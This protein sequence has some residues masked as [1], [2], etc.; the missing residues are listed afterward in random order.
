MVALQGGDAGDPAALAD[1]GRTSRSP[2]STSVYRNLDVMLAPSDVVGES[3][4]NP[5]LD[6]VVEDLDAPG[7]LVESGGA[8][9]VFPPGFTNRD[10]EPLPLIVRKCDE[11]YG[12]AAT[13]LAAIRDRVGTSRRRMLYVV[14]APQAQH[15]EMCFAVARMAGW[16]P[17]GERGEHVAFGNGARS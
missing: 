17:E 5:M 4:Y 15:F 2:T 1:P 3:Y 12:Y 10:G 14:G 16:L 9:C 11:G 13:D 7:L 6:A 8:A